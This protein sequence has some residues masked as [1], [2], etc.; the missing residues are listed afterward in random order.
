MGDGT[1]SKSYIYVDDIVRGIQHFVDRDTAPFTYYHLA[2]GDYITVRE[3]ADLVAEE[4]HLGNVEY[5][6][7]GGSR[8]WA[9]DVPIVR[10]D[11][12]KAWSAGWRAE[13]SSR[14]AMRGAIRSMLAQE[15]LD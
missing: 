10:F 2:T 15:S 11:L 9:G 12:S 1:Q 5:E 14:E 13:R 8:G 7:G 6:F 4:M 3:I